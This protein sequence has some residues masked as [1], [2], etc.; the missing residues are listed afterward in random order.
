MGNEVLDPTTLVAK[1]S[2][3][4]GE[5]AISHSVFTNNLAAMAN[6]PQNYRLPMSPMTTSTA[7]STLT[8][9]AYR[10][11]SDP[12]TTKPQKSSLNINSFN[13][14]KVLGRGSFGKVLLAEEK[15]TNQ[16]FAIKALKKHVV[17]ED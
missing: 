16:I 9:A 8:D 14:L 15:S 17:C 11:K 7:S 5:P 4:P 13:Y 3:T 12:S 1:A 6:L 10:S 2:L